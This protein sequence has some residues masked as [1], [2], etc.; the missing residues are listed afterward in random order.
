MV[1]FESLG[2]VSYS[3]SVVN[4]ALAGIISEIKRDIVPKLCFFHTPLHLTLPL[5]RSRRNSAI[6]FGVEKLEWWSTRRWKKS[7]DTITR[8]DRIHERKRRTH[9]R[10][11]TAWRHRPRLCIASRG[12]KWSW[13]HIR[14]WISTEINCPCLPNLVDIDP[15]VSVNYLADRRTHTDTRTHTQ[16][17]AIYLLRQRREGNYLFYLHTQTIFSCR[18]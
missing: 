5:G 11:D 17:I 1:P 6:P 8:F 9:R 18:V 14:N 4:M 10:T 12:K 15:I 13:F 16:V 2:M 7:D 3:P